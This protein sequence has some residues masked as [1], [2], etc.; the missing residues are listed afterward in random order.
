MVERV[1]AAL[2]ELT[3]PA[4]VAARLGLPAGPLCLR[5]AWPRSP[6]HLLLE[7]VGADAEPVPGQWWAGRSAAERAVGA[8]DPA[9]VALVA[10]GAAPGA[11]ALQ[12]RGAD[13]RLP[14]LAPL[15]RRP[16]ARLLAHQPGRRAVV[17]LPE[18]DGAVFA[19]VVR[20][21]RAEALAAAGAAANGLGGGAFATPRLLA[22][23]ARAGVVRWTALAGVALHQLPAG[24]AL[25][26]G[27]RAAGR[28]LRA[29]HEAAPP[30]Q[31]REHGPADERETLGRWA[32]LAGAYDPATGAAL[33]DLAAA[34]GEAL[35]ATCGP[36]VT[37]HRDFY[38]KQIMVAE[39]ARIGLLDFDTLARAEPAL[40]LAN[41]LVH[42]ELRA[43]QGL[44]A[45]DQAARARRALCAG[46]D[47]APAVQARLDAYASAACLRLACVYSLRPRWRRCVAP[48]LDLARGPAPLLAAG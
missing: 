33:A 44:L 13:P 5:R 40:D 12:L 4:E 1:L 26:E 29:L 16:G 30:P 47:P 21:G 20:P 37:A 15:L 11:V 23:D 8:A 36:L 2:A 10:P 34:V 32:A 48:L 22:I 14:G 7:Y 41:A 17:R 6:E 38:D 45:G 18:G 39:G 25:V 31:A 28:A 27:A 19:K 24:P 3:P 46:Y 9:D 43:L 42:F 35:T